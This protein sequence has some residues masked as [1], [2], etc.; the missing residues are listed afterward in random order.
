MVERGIFANEVEEAIKSGSKELQRPDKILYHYR[1]F[2]VVTKKV[3]DEHF[4]ITVMLR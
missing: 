3:D 4:V 1:Y 2:T